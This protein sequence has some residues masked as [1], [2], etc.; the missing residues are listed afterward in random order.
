MGSQ[1]SKLTASF[2]RERFIKWALCKECL[3]ERAGDTTLSA[4]GDNLP[5]ATETPQCRSGDPE[6]AGWEAVN[7]N[8]TFCRDLWKVLSAEAPDNLV[9]SPLG[10]SLVMGAL[11]EGASGRTLRKIKET[12]HF[13]Y[14]S[15]R[16][17]GHSE[18]LISLG[19]V[20]NPIISIASRMFVSKLITLLPGFTDHVMSTYSS[21]PLSVDF[22]DPV[23]TARTINAW[24]ASS[25]RGLISNLIEPD[26]I[27]PDA[28]LILANA[29]YFKGTWEAEFDPEMTT[30]DQ[31]DSPKGPRDVMMMRQRNK[32]YYSPMP[33]EDC[34]ML[35]M[36]YQGCRFAM[37]FLLPDEGA[38]LHKLS[39]GLNHPQMEDL[40]TG[41]KTI[42]DVCVH[43]PRFKVSHKLDLSQS[44]C[45]LGLTEM[46]S[47]NANFSR[48]SPTPLLV[49]K[50][51]QTAIVEVTEEGCE[52]AAVTTCE[53]VDRCG[54]GST[55]PPVVY[56][57]MNR[58]FLYRIVDLVSGVLLFQG[59]VTDPTL[60]A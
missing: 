26:E 45:D 13:D 29:I 53:M 17:A 58:P 3:N 32:F 50:V 6:C 30:P 23:S 54:G 5:A 36:P 28:K 51:R 16:R 14:N 10:I 47:Q 18:L 15:R 40:F 24:S 37:Q 9:F 57:L 12:M 52:A 59:A 60:S 34:T 25:T 4:S 35:E 33:G 20:V 41:T 44:L 11:A 43:L 48:L 22:L 49:S 46:F 56:F 1:A 19:K 31:F 7:A 21:S 38:D 8:N 55:P 27:H 42:T 39:N 2:A